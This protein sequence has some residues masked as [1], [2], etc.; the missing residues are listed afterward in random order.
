MEVRNK[1][2]VGSENIG[3]DEPIL[4]KIR[5]YFDL[6]SEPVRYK[7]IKIS[8]DN[9]IVLQ[10][11]YHHFFAIEQRGHAIY[12]VNYQIQE[13]RHVLEKKISVGDAMDLIR[14]F[15]RRHNVIPHKFNGEGGS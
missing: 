11:D 10:Y 5:A 15:R 3:H 4:E 7:H 14:S 13:N 9:R 1:K 2:D 12:K 8:Q 6:S